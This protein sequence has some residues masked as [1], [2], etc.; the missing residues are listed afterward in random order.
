MA[1]PVPVVTVNAEHV[2]QVGL[3]EHFLRDCSSGASRGSRPALRLRGSSPISFGKVSA[4]L[5][6]AAR[7]LMPLSLPM[8][9]T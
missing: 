3:R 1:P 7:G 4:T 2:E 9:A 8:T 5:P 6:V